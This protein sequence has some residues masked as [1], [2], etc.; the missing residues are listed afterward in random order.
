VR[1]IGTVTA[2]MRCLGPGALLVGLLAVGPT[3]GAAQVPSSIG[4]EDMAWMLRNLRPEGQPVIPIFEGWYSSDDGTR[5]LCFGYYN[6][7]TDEAVEIP[8]GPDNFIEPARFDGAQPTHFSEVPPEARRH[9]CVFTVPLPSDFGDADVTW[10]LTRDGQSFS[11][12]GHTTSIHYQIEEP[13][14]ASRNHESPLVRFVSPSGPE[15]RGRSGGLVASATAAVGEPLEVIV[16]VAK[17]GGGPLGRT[18]VVWDKHQ[19]PGEVL[20]S[21]PLVDFRATGE[22][23]VEFSTRATILEPGE[24]L[25]RVQAIDWSL[26][27]PF[28][29]ECCWTNGF[30]RVTVGG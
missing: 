17:P 8:L 5:T 15:G 11:V 16:S 14:N 12:P 1:R 21:E 22:S 24:Y 10:T 29:Y 19:G 13:D 18:R 7:N 3:P 20:F 25:L 4:N 2:W 30:V 6:L 9:F 28:G 27:N 23:Q 26:G